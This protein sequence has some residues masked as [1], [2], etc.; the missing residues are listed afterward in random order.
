[1]GTA[2]SRCDIQ[3][4]RLGNHPIPKMWA[5]APADVDV[6]APAEQIGQ[7][8]LDSGQGEERHSDARLELGQYVH[9]A[10]PG[11]ILA[12]DGTEERE[13]SKPVLLTE[14]RKSLARHTQSLL[15]Q[16]ST[17]LGLL[18]PAFNLVFR[19]WQR[20]RRAALG[21]PPAVPQRGW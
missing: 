18:G 8:V 10:G 3:V 14:F 5:E 11:E 21:D 17:M 7:V 20:P 15:G 13:A 2:A 19:A 6:R 16:H 4:T 12:E 1:M 9:V